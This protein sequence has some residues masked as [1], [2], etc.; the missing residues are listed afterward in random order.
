MFVSIL[1]GY[2]YNTAGTPY[3]LAFF[4]EPIQGLL[5]RTIWYHEYS[6]VCDSIAL[7]GMNRR[8]TAC[9]LTDTTTEH[10]PFKMAPLKTAVCGAMRSAPCARLPRTSTWRKAETG[11]A[12]V[13][14]R[15]LKKATAATHFLG[16]TCLLPIFSRKFQNLQRL[17]HNQQLLYLYRFPGFD[18][19][20]R[21]AHL[22]VLITLSRQTDRQTSSPWTV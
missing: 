4:L 12:A 14:Y 1:I 11:K 18:E 13:K 21:W 2:N 15:T 19:Y 20:Y 9:K 5:F 22:T 17:Q 3:V 7:R 6:N 16:G 10:R 8:K